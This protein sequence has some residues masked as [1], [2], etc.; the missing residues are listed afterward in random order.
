MESRARSADRP[1]RVGVPAHRRR[2]PDPHREVRRRVLA[3]LAATRHEPRAPAQ[4][5]AVGTHRG[6]RASSGSS[7][8]DREPSAR[9]RQQAARHRARGEDR[10]RTELA[11][12]IVE[13]L[14]FH[15]TH[16]EL[17]VQIAHGAAT[18][19]AAV[20]TGRVAR[21]R[22]PTLHER[23][24]LAARAWIRHRHTNYED[25]LDT[26]Y[27]DDLLLDELTDQ[28]VKS[29]ANQTVDDFIAAHRAAP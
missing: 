29:A 7:K 26:T 19:A 3:S 6:D 9:G 23:A 17:A 12:A 5:R 8:P 13:F 28:A 24:G 11:A 15:P 27:G 25:R 4:A 21:T 14:A 1:R 18:Q 16:H 10:Y 22:A 2:L 20:G